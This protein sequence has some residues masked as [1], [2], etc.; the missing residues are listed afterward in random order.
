[1]KRLL[2]SLL[3]L[4]LVSPV[5]AADSKA[6]EPAKAEA[7][8]KAAKAKEPKVASAEDQLLSSSLSTGQKTKLLSILNT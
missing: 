7:K 5:L 3:M 8:S 4:G 1:M 6:K 2:V